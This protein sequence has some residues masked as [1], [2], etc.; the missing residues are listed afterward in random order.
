MAQAVQR[1]E[2]TGIRAADKVIE[3]DVIRINFDDNFE[4]VSVFDKEEKREIISNGES[5]NRLEI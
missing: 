4:I 2:E 1:L 5:A 3:N